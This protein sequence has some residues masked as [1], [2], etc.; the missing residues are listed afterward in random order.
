MNVLDPCALLSLVLAWLEVTE[1]GVRAYYPHLVIGVLVGMEHSKGH[2]E[3][4]PDV[5]DLHTF[6]SSIFVS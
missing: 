1:F 2:G 4:F 3:L 5:I 6:V